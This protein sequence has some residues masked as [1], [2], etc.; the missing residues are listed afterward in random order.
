MGCVHING[1]VLCL[2]DGEVLTK[3]DKEILSEFVDY[4]REESEK[5][6]DVN[7][8]GFASKRRNVNNNGGNQISRSSENST[9]TKRTAN[10]PQKKRYNGSD[11]K[12]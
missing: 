10:A 6:K 7:L 8:K 2:K 9:N 5:K 4:L 3:E 11:N 12:A 1:A